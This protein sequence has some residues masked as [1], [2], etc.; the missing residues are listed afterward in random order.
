VAQA[1]T[2]ALIRTPFTC[3]GCGGQFF[4]RHSCPSMPWG[5]TALGPF[6]FQIPNLTVKP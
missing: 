6:Y 2:Q 5:K 1:V 4:D 3:S